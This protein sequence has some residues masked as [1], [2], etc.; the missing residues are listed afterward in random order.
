[1][2]FLPSLTGSTKPSLNSAT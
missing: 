1:M 2:K